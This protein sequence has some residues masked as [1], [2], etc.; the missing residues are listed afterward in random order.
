MKSDK[1]SSVELTPCGCPDAVHALT[2]RCTR[3]ADQAVHAVIMLL[4]LWQVTRQVEEGTSEV[5]EL[6]GKLSS[7]QRRAQRHEQDMAEAEA[8]R[9]GLQEQLN[10]LRGDVQ[11]LQASLEHAQHDRQQVTEPLL[12]PCLPQATHTHDSSEAEPTPRFIPSQTAQSLL[13]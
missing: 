13:S 8:V 11:A 5:A 4:L 6:Q 10:A 12:P 1:V 7:A 9:A 3:W 2:V